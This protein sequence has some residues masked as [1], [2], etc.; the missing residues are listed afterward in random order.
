MDQETTYRPAESNSGDNASND[1]H[2]N[3]SSDQQ[4]VCS[5]DS[6]AITH[7][8]N[9]NSS[10]SS[11]CSSSDD[12]EEDSESTAFV[13]KC[14]ELP[15]NAT[16]LHSDF[17]AAM[18]VKFKSMSLNVPFRLKPKSQVRQEL[19]ALAALIQRELD[20]SNNSF[21]KVIRACHCVSDGTFRSPKTTAELSCELYD[22]W[23]TIH[24]KLETG[25][26]DAATIAVGTVDDNGTKT[27]TNTTNTR[28]TSSTPLTSTPPLTPTTITEATFGNTPIV[29]YNVSELDG[30][31]VLKLYSEIA[32]LSRYRDDDMGLPCFMPPWL[33]PDKELRRELCGVQQSI[34]ELLGLSGDVIRSCQQR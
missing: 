22:I 18:Y 33:R 30:R 8:P 11:S 9:N 6:I 20:E 32:A 7:D 10:S 15:A 4:I 23:A 21:T 28:A 25:A 24:C 17:L 12:D 16:E 3:L 27:N 2:K 19:Q 34:Q 1:A 13:R 26:N 14:L 31:A 29:N 5:R